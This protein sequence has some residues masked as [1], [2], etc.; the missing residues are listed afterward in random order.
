MIQRDIAPKIIELFKYYPI[1]SLTGPR[2]SGK[3]TLLKSLFTGKPYVTLEDPDARLLAT[4]DPRRFLDVYTEGAI[5]D[6]VQNVPA[7]FSY[8]QGIVDNNPKIKFVLSGSQNF[9]LLQN[10]SQSLAGRVG[11]LN[12][13]PFSQA[14]I[15]RT[16]LDLS[17]YETLFRG[18]YPAIY[19]RDTPP[20]VF[21]SNYLTTYLERD[22][23]SI[24]NV[25]NLTVFNRFLRLCAGRAG[26]I[27]NMA[28]LANDVGVSPLTIKSWLSVLEASNIVVLLQPHFENLGKRLIKMPKLYFTDTGIVC[29]LLNIASAEQLMTHHAIGAIFE[30]YVVIEL[31]KQRLNKGLSSNLYFWRDNHGNEIDLLAET[32]NGIVSIEIKSAKTY[33]TDFSKG[34]RY[35]QNLSNQPSEK[36]YIVYGGD[37]TQDTNAGQLLSWKKLSDINIE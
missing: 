8:L 6:E 22:V 24:I 21:F 3:T 34:L 29:Y 35:W 33:N 31:L 37:F 17:L 15:K 20:N 28:S 13:L 1:V 27:I 10:I 5:F 14:E 12:L 11:I 16:G 25:G 2:Q 19:D 7:L 30:N 26:Q 4:T 32:S 18:S 9:L 23:R 36:S